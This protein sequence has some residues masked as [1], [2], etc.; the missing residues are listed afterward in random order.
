MIRWLPNAARW[1]ATHKARQAVNATVAIV[2]AAAKTL[3]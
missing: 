3:D 1:K 2:I